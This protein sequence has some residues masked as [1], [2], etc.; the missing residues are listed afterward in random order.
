MQPS[1]TAA[2]LGCVAAELLA[3]G[4]R[5]GV[6]QVGATGFD[7]GRPLLRLGLQRS[8][9]VG[10]R[11]HQVGDDALG[12]GHV[13]GGREDVVGRLRSV[14]VVVRVHL[15]AQG[16]SRQGGQHLVGVH[17]RAGARPG[18]EYVDREV[19]VDLTR[20]HLLG[21]RRDRS[22]DLAFHHA[23]PGVHRRCRR[24]D[25]RERPDLASLQTTARDR[26]VLDCPLGLRL[27][28]R[29]HRHPHVTHGV[30]FDAVLP[31]FA[32]TVLDRPGCRRA[33]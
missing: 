29:V 32:R 12:R 14:D 7:D 25:Q 31:G 18:L 21:R 4:D 10:Q 5:G 28:Q 17:V 16:L 22:G 11:R 9:E 1:D 13:D 33:R 26:K 3:Q 20:G 23:Q 19:P 30:V 24:L 27:V 8:G 15:A 2:H 6:H